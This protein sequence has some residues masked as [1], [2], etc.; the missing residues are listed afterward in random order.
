M[1]LIGAALTFLVCAFALWRGGAAERAA[2][3]LV[4]IVLAVSLIG[5]AVAGTAN[6]WPVVIADLGLGA[7]LTGLSFRYARR[8]L[9]VSIGF[10]AALLLVHSFLLEEGAVVTPLYQTLVDGLDIALLVTLTVA[11]HN[12]RRRGD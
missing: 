10:C 6:A 7:G 2:A 11:T 4:L 8:W 1:I 9:Y 3:V 12:S 5:Q